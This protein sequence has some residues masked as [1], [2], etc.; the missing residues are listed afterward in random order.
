[1]KTDVEK[2][3]TLIIS[4]IRR[5][6]VSSGNAPPG[7]ERFERETGITQGRWRGVVWARWSDA[8]AEAG[9]SANV[10]N[11]R[12]DSEFVMRKLAEAVRYYGRFPTTAEMSLYKRND[13]EFPNK[14]VFSTHHGSQAALAH[15][16]LKWCEQSAGYDDVAALM[17]ASA[18]QGAEGLL[19]SK[20]EGWVYLLGSGIH[21]KIGRSEEIERRVNEIRPCLP[22]ATEIIHVIKTDDPAGIEAY[23]HRRFADRR[24]NGEWF[25]LTRED[26]AAFKR[27][28]FQ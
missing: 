27:R 11:P 8:L 6:A 2:L 12:Y 17:P 24:A 7:V 19:Q 26:I 13:P 15:A 1:M 5:L 20:G 28:K 3:R 21:F 18:A 23:W 9:Y 16:L 25:K 10:F 4:E 22:E 14:K